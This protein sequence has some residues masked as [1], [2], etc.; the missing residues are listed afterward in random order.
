MTVNGIDQYIQNLVENC[1][2]LSP[3]FPKFENDSIQLA[4]IIGNALL[5]KFT[6][7]QYASRDTA[8]FVRVANGFIPVGPVTSLRLS[9]NSNQENIPKPDFDF[10]NVDLSNENLFT[11]SVNRVKRTERSKNGHDDNLI[12]K[13]PRKYQASVNFALNCEENYFSIEIRNG[14][15]YIDLPWNEELLRKVPSN[16]NLSKVISKKVYC[17]NLDKK[18]EDRYIEVFNEQLS[19]G[20]IEEIPS[21]FNPEQFTWIPNRPVIRNDPLVN[22]TKVRPVFNCSLKV[23]NCPSLNEAAYPG[24]NILNDMLDLLHYFRTNKYCFLSDIE[25]AF[26]MVKLKSVDDKIDFHL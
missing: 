22:S 9:L 19:L 24:V 21:G 8:S 23:K 18:V 4:G 2:P 25:K 17:Q 16:F 3:N 12:F 1:F 15:F 6:V 11:N 20:I 10:S 26:L 5:P 14:Y 7:F 13:V